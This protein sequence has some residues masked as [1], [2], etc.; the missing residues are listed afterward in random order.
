VLDSPDVRVF[1]RDGR[2]ILS[3]DDW[4]AKSPP[5][6]GARHWKDYRSAKELAKSWFRTPSA[7]P[8]QE[9]LSFLRRSFPTRGI[10]LTD[11][12]PECVVPL[13]HFGG[14]QRNADLVILGTAGSQTLLISIEAK[15]DEPFG[16][17]LIGQYYDRG[18]AVA[19]SK[20]PARIASLTCALFNA[21]PDL[22][23]RSLRY[24]LLHATAGTLIEARRRHAEVAIFLVHEF[25]SD[26]LNPA[27]LACN[28]NDWQAFIAALAADRDAELTTDHAIGPITVHGGE[29]VPSNIPLYLGKV[30]TFLP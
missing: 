1:S 28:Q 7:S 9:L 10:V 5:K 25:L 23:T 17:H 22:R 29:H 8:P 6:Q 12:Y 4:L 26:H 18:R 16:D 30:Q 11:A 15:A 13:D 19:G 3:V 2:E 20:V 24:Q 21:D 27:R 14:E